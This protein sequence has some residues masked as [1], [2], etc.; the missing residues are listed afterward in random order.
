MRVEI[1]CSRILREVAMEIE[2]EPCLTEKEE[3]VE[4]VGEGSAW[5]RQCSALGMGRD[6]PGVLLKSRDVIY[7]WTYTEG[8]SQEDL[9]L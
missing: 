7:V 3:V 8:A 6:S 2:Q 5:Y 9:L 1:L 4:Q